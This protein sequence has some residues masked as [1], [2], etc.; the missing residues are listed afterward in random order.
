MNFV[1]RSI[2]SITRR[3]DKTIIMLVII[4]ILSSI[5]SGS[6]SVYQAI[7]NTETRLLKQISAAA[8]IGFDSDKMSNF[9]EEDYQAMQ[10]LSAGTIKKIGSL[11]SVKYYD[12]SSIA[13]L[14]SNYLKS[15]YEDQEN[16]MMEFSRGAKE[17]FSLKGVEQPELIDI[18]E[19]KIKL[20]EGRTFKDDEM[21]SLTY[22]A[23]ISKNFAKLN[24]LNIASKF[25]LEN[26]VYD[27][28]KS[29]IVDY[30]EMKPVK[31][32]KYEFEVIGI[33]EPVKRAKESNEGKIDFGYD[34]EI[35]NRIYA[36]NPVVDAA[37]Q[38]MTDEYAKLDEESEKYKDQGIYYTT[39]YILNSPADINEFREQASELIPDYYKVF[40]TGRSFEMSIAPM[41]S[42]QW[43]FSLVLYIAIGA[44]VV[45]LSLLMTLFMK[46]R[47]HEMGIYLSLGEKK[48]RIVSQI[49]IEIVLIAVAAITGALFAGN[50]LAGSISDKM[51][52]D[53]IIAEQSK[54]K[55]DYAEYSELEYMGYNADISS[56]E[57]LKSYHVSL[58]ILTI[59][60]FYVIGVGTVFISTL[61]PVIYILRLNPKKIMM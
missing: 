29:D 7:N 60:I 61:M 31:S 50:L 16:G 8:T 51:L 4:F 18:K 42:M 35:E 12:Y 34:Q 32:Q 39:L 5:I 43:I 11:P 27:Y 6:I 22:V 9:S 44:T 45:V 24:N 30:E 1:K 10:Y 37:Q 59:I 54:S 14:E 46:D 26:N 28:T 41:K 36:P 15:Y 56:D 55:N 13:G 20:T 49:V 33:F 21:K 57:L 19:N 38:Y 53:Q 52:N 3:M 23:V 25:T 40:D 47:K 17:Y 58:D 2:T 48:M